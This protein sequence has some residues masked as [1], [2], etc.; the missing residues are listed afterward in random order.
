MKTFVHSWHLIFNDK[1]ESL[2][3]PHNSPIMKIILLILVATI[4]GC[5]CSKTNSNKNNI[6][7]DVVNKAIADSTKNDSLA[8]YPK[9]VRDIIVKMKAD[10]VTNP[11]SKI[12]SYS[13]NDKT[14]YYVPGVCCDNFSDLYD[15][16][17]KII[18]HPDGGFTGKGDRK[19]P[20]FHD[21]KKNE[22]LIWED[23][24]KQ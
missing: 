9:C 16:S 23:N 8:M 20:T 22:K 5:K 21:E 24:R 19:M 6:P 12:Y 17:C 14:V 18:A 13:F 11:P 1:D 10:S 2:K 7:L 4:F 15:D 3:L